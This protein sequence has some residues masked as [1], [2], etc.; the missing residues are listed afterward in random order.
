MNYYPCL[1]FPSK[2]CERSYLIVLLICT[3]LASF[4][5]YLDFPLD[6]LCIHTL[7]LLSNWDVFLYQF[8]EVFKYFEH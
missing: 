6:E 7:C 3:S 4:T 8:V 5:L 2:V 1:I